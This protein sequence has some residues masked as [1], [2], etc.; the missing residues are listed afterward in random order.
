MVDNKIR[1]SYSK[2]II[3]NNVRLYKLPAAAVGTQFTIF[4]SHSTSVQSRKSLKGKI[5][6]VGNVCD[7]NRD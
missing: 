2:A 1:F 6:S 3:C 4:A 5:S 7:H